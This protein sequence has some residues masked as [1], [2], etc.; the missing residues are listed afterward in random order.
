RVVTGYSVKNFCNCVC[1]AVNSCLVSRTRRT[2]LSGSVNHSSKGPALMGITALNMTLCHVAK[3]PIRFSQFVTS[4]IL[5]LR[6]K[7]FAETGKTAEG[8]SWSEGFDE[9]G[10]VLFRSHPVGGSCFA[11]SSHSFTTG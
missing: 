1:S 6:G 10:K 2:R 5:K 4:A 3:R 9:V 11:L 7:E 8:R